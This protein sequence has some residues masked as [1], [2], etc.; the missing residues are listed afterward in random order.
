MRVCVCVRRVLRDLAVAGRPLEDI[1]H[2]PAPNVEGVRALEVDK[3]ACGDDESML[4]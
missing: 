2:D 1:V 4:L 3:A